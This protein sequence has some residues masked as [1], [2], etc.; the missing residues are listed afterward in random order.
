MWRS[1]SGL[2]ESYKSFSIYGHKCFLWK[3]ISYAHCCSVLFQYKRVMLHVVLFLNCI[4]CLL[5]ME[6]GTMMDSFL[7]KQAEL[8]EEIKSLR[9]ENQ[10]L[11]DLY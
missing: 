11:R 2:C 1:C 7:A 6:M 8:V 4:N 5:Q 10:Q 9:R 3:S